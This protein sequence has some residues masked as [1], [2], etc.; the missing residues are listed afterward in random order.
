MGRRKLTTS[1]PAAV[2]IA[3]DCV[4]AWHAEGERL[5]GPDRMQWRFVCPVCGHI[6]AAADWERAGAP[7]ETVGFS[8]IGRWINGSRQAF[9]G[10]GPGP[11]NYAG[12]GLFR[13]NPVTIKGFED[14]FFAFADPVGTSP[15]AR[16]A[17]SGKSTGET[18]LRVHRVSSERCP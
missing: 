8:C 14:S 9:G 11:C 5:F 16:R 2:A 18:G 13:M 6:A 17:H 3:Y 4:A 7:K 1:E 15:Q 10:S 12:G